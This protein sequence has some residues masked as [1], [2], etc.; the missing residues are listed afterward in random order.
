MVVTNMILFLS[1]A[2]VIMFVVLLL[3]GFIF[4]SEK[5]FEL[6]RGMKTG[7]AIVIGIAVVIAILWATGLGGPGG[8]YDFLFKQSWSEAFW[9]NLIFVV[10]IGIALGVII[11]NA[12]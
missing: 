5:G 9:T 6:P 3:W 8:V 1:V 2:L 12:K 4:A 7:L 10:L 11:K